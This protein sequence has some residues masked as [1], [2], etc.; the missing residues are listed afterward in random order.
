LECPSYG[1][2]FSC[3][4]P[5]LLLVYF[6]CCCERKRSIGVTLNVPFWVEVLEIQSYQPEHDRY[7][8]RKLYRLS[9]EL[10][11]RHGRS[12]ESS[13]EFLAEA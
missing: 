2:Q 1:H 4:W 9:D 13:P 8:L 7:E 11:E 3:L 6:R 12:A 10:T 5:C